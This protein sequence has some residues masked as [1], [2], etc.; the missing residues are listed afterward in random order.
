[1]SRGM[2]RCDRNPPPIRERMHCVTRSS[3]AHRAA[4]GL[5]AVA[6]SHQRRRLGRCLVGHDP[7]RRSDDHRRWSVHGQL[8]LHGRQ[9][10]PDRPGRPLLRDGRRDRHQRLHRRRPA[11]G[12]QRA[13]PGGPVPGHAG[14]LRLEHHAGG[15]RNQPRCLRLQRLLPGDA[16]T[17]GTTTASTRPSLSSAGRRASVPPAL[18]S[19]RRSTP[20]ATPAFGWASRNCPPTSAPA[21][22]RPPMAGP[23]RSTR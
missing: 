10:H 5:V 23:P 11:T 8:H 13:D 1:M 16:S 15:R 7:S 9:R 2:A 6:W 21:W 22:V 17:H 3:P 14:V 18:R 12:D 4:C 19:A 20:T